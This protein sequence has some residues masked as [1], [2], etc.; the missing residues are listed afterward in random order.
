MNI[1]LLILIIAIGLLFI[2][3]EIFLIPG[4][5]VLTV[6]GLAVVGTGV[7]LGYTE[8]GSTT[9]HILFVT[10]II[11]TGIMLY[12]GYRRIQ[13][14]KWALYTT[15]DGRVN[16][17]DLTAFKV[18]DKGVS[19]TALRPEGFAVFGEGERQTVFS[20]GEFIDKDTEVEIIK[21][22]QNK[23]F[24]KPVNANYGK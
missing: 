18:G 4:T 10:S 15:I 9:G 20:Q 6:L 13:S 7:F 22:E 8:Y 3:I 14:K 11:G 24:V 5:S 21:I 19:V 12:I 16:N 23:L 2:F 1:L 17:E